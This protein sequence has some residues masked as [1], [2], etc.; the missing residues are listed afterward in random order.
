MSTPDAY[1]PADRLADLFRVL[2]DPGRLRL[3]AAIAAAGEVSVTALSAA[4]GQPQPTV[5]HHLGL[6]RMH[7]MVMSRRV[8][9]QV[10]Y[11]L[12]PAAA[13]RPADGRLCLV[14]AEGTTIEIDLAPLLA[15]SAPA[16]ALTPAGRGLG[17]RRRVRGNI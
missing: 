14:A 13:T 10:H 17:R 3:L 1:G 2:S 12:A 15:P 6:L 16:A 9:K 4:L 11:S 5:S 8:G 7:R